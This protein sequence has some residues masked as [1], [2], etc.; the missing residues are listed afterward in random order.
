MSALAQEALFPKADLAGSSGGLPLSPAEIICWDQ[1]GVTPA[2]NTLGEGLDWDGQQ[3][4]RAV[5]FSLISSFTLSD[6]VLVRLFWQGKC[7]MFEISIDFII[8]NLCHFFHWYSF[9][10]QAVL[11]NHS[12]F[13]TDL[14]LHSPLHPLPAPCPL[15][16]LYTHR[17][18]Y[19]LY[20]FMHGGKTKPLKILIIFYFS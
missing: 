16:H 7:N 3:I 9:H 10:W 15:H 20:V 19:V 14:S 12:S 18:P 8:N 5:P 1:V 6:R 13:F 17:S 2:I 11:V 4:G